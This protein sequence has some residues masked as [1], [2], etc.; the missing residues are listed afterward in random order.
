MSDKPKLKRYDIGHC[1]DSQCFGGPPVLEDEE[2]DYVFYTDIAQDRAI[3][4][5]AKAYV[6]VL[7]DHTI[8][9]IDAA[10]M[11]LVAAVKGK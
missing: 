8:D 3:A 9:G 4:Q 6:E 5:A 7:P 11:A 10:Y 2:G 1:C